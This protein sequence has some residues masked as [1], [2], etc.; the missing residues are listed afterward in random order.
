VVP[1][2]SV[3][4]HNLPPLQVFTETRVN[5]PPSRSHSDV[6]SAVALCP[7]GLTLVGARPP[8]RTV[9][10]GAIV[11]SGAVTVPPGGRGALWAKADVAATKAMPRKPHVNGVTRMRSSLVFA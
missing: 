6:V 9:A 2:R 7:P 5:F 3:V 11:P 8:G 10:G 4:V 1:S